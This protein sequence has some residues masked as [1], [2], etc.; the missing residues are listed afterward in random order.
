MSA[1][2]RF[3]GAASTH[4]GAYHAAEVFAPEAPLSGR[5][6]ARRFKALCRGLA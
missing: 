1:Q 2:L 4:P 3:S 5:I 6:W